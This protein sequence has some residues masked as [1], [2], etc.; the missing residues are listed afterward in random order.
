[1]FPKIANSALAARQPTSYRPQALNTP[2]QV[3]ALGARQRHQLL[4][5]RLDF[6]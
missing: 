2:G 6:V 1:M 4:P 3:A 5:L